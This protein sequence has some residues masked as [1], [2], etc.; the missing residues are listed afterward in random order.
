MRG[1]ERGESGMTLKELEE[2]E[3]RLAKLVAE[4][5]G[6]KKK[7]DKPRLVRRKLSLCGAA[8]GGRRDDRD[9]GGGRAMRAPTE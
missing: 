9:G 6:K 4:T 8:R 2:I 7:R 1:T 3:K 5:S